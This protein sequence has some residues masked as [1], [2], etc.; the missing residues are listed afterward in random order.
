MKAYPSGQLSTE[1]TPFIE[2]YYDGMDLRD[3]FAAK[4]TEG[5]VQFYIK[6]T[7]KRVKNTDPEKLPF[8]PTHFE[9]QQ[10]TREQAKYMYADA[11]ME[12]REVNP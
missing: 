11:M 2:P 12:A 1:I 4:A 8:D 9:E 10:I 7:T 6:M 3:Y 5:D